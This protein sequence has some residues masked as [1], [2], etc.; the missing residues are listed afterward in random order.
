MDIH[1]QGDRIFCF[2]GAKQLCDDLKHRYYDIFIKLLDRKIGQQIQNKMADPITSYIISIQIHGHLKQVLLILESAAW[3]KF[4]DFQKV[5]CLR[6]QLGLIFFV[7]GTIRKLHYLISQ[8]EE[9]PAKLCPR[10]F[11]LLNLV[12]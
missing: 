6:M 11:K 1:C 9:L 8:L 10:H 12:Y 2:M 5:Y 3:R 4:E 7:K